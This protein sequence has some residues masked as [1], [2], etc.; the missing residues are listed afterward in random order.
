M[1]GMR[2]L[3]PLC[4][5]VALLTT[6]TVRA[7]EPAATSPAPRVLE[8]PAFVALSVAKLEPAMEW[9]GKLFGLTTAMRFDMP[10]HS[11]RIAILRSPHFLVELIEHKG[12]AAPTAD[13]VKDRFKEHGIFKAGFH[14]PDIDAF[15]EALEAHGAT[16][17]TGI[18]NS[19]ALG[20]RFI[21]FKDNE[22]N[23]LQAFE[24]PK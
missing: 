3:I 14:V 12:A 20:L 5:Q 8:A 17:D 9:Y 6:A 13:I 2:I 10:D 19:K 7:A 18:I 16:L 1:C 11:G 22:G 21:V 24:A 23:L 4:F 15:L